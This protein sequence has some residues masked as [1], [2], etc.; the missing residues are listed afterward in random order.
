MNATSYATSVR[1]AVEQAAQASNI[2]WGRL[3]RELR[4]HAVL[5]GFSL[6]ATAVA[7]TALSALVDLLR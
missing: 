2:P 1:Q 5:F 7:A 4:T 6:T 3:A